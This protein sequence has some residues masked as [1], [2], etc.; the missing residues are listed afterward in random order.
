MAKFHFKLDSVLR[1]RA[2][3]EDQ[4]Q[5]E[6]AQLLRERMILH[7]QLR[8]MQNTI[9]QSKRDLGG[10]LVGRV[11]MGQ[12][13]QFAR[14]SGQATQRAQEIVVRLASLEKQ[15]EASRI[16]LMEAVRARKALEL[17]RDRHLSMWRREQDRR[18]A[19]FL[20]EIAT[21]AFGRARMTEYQA[22]PT[23]AGPGVGP[24]ISPGLGS[25][26]S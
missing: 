6:L 25:R 2:L 14:F 21:G 5:R 19:S 18:E 1:H 17:L 12:V 22:V 26:Y 7:H 13:A 16:R 11:D 9:S 15:I 3:V 20:D 23:G 10:G 8:Q 24:G 4:C